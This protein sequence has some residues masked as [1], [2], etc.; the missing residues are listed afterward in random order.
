MADAIEVFTPLQDDITGDGVKWPARKRGDDAAASGNLAPVTAWR[1]SSGA[2]TLPQLTA[3]GAVPVD[4]GG[5]S[6]TPADGHATVAGVK[7]TD[8]TVVAIT[9]TAS[10]D[11]ICQEVLGAATKTTLWKLIHHDNGSD[12]VLAKF[13]TGA[14][15]PSFGDK[16]ANI[17]FTAGAAGTQELRL[18]GRLTQG[19]NTDLHGTLATLEL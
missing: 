6:G 9:L 18:I 4:T 7:D 16:L 14:G 19:E 3:T 15:Q 12:N 13:I 5:A 17:K 11:Y 8:T 1:D 10:A 2:Y